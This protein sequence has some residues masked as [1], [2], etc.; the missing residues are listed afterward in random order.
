MYFGAIVFTVMTAPDLVL[1]PRNPPLREEGGASPERRYHTPR[2]GHT[3]RKY[4]RYVF[5]ARLVVTTRNYARSNGYHLGCDKFCRRERRP[6]KTLRP[7]HTY[8]DGAGQTGAHG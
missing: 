1:V 6:I 3:R 5:D 7:P 8:F 2:C 4:D